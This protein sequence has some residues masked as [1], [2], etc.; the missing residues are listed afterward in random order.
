MMLKFTLKNTQ[1]IVAS[2]FLIL[3]IGLSVSADTPV[4]T[5]DLNIFS[6]RLIGPFTFSGRITDFA[7]PEGQS[8]VY[9]VA[10]AT[11]GLRKTEDGG[12]HFEPIFDKY[13]NMSMGHIAVAPSDHNILYLSDL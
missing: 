11:G 13:G 8:L 10:T 1:R 6:W 5:K 3:T 2:I 7:V 12:I 9:Y 4:T